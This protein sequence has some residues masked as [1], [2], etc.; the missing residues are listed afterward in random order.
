ME[1]DKF[2]HFGHT[3]SSYAD[4]IEEEERKAGA[5]SPICEA[6]K[7]ANHLF[8]CMPDFSK[9]GMKICCSCRNC[10][11]NCHD[12]MFGP[13]CIFCFLCFCNQMPDF[14][15]NIVL[16]KI[17]IDT[18]NCELAF[19]MF[20]QAKGVHEDWVFPPPCMQD[21]SYGYM[22]FWYE[23]IFEGKWQMDWP[24]DDELTEGCDDDE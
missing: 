3:W 17:F 15:D 8:L 13:Y 19:T 4:Y 23:W 21:N 14:V 16:K 9:C 7:G 18:Y 5:D 11:T 1:G 10:M 22:T 6:A 24:A 2:V 20:K 12:V